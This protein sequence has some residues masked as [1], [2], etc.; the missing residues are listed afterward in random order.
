MGQ[1]LGILDAM[2][3]LKDDALQGISNYTGD[4]VVTGDG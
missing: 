2:S 3:K 1:L 4:P